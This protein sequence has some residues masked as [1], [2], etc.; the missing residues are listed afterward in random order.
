[1][2]WPVS[3]KGVILDGDAVVLLHNER[4]E[5]ELPGGRLEVGES[6][7]ECVRREIEEELGIA[8]RVD[9]LIDTW[10]YEVF[11]G[12]RVLIVTYGCTAES[13]D[14]IAHSDE[15][16]DVLLA[17][18]D[19]LHDLELPWGYLV[20]I[21]TWCAMSNVGV[22]YHRDLAGRLEAF[23]PPV[24]VPDGRGWRVVGVEG[25]IDVPN[26]VVV[27][28]DDGMYSVRTYSADAPDEPLSTAV[29][30]LQRGSLN[31]S[32]PAVRAR[33]NNV[34]VE[35]SQREVV[36]DDE[37]VAVR[38]LES[39]NSFSFSVQCNGRRVRVAGDLRALEG[40]RLRQLTALAEMSGLT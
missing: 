12:E 24:F 31:S 6:P 14:G 20:S 37:P 5:W 34:V 38:V 32:D 1:M 8:V 15:H 39:H 10:V 29:E 35:E 25:S 2:R 9:A 26:G 40:L 23:G 19:T 22:T 21:R 30:N 33:Y 13:L 36:V 16:D 18:V 11:P 7:Q 17:P 27:F 4:D 3:I 28:A